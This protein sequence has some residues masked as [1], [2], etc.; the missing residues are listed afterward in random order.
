MEYFID[1]LLD[2]GTI[3]EE[4][5]KTFRPSV[6]NRLD[7]NTSGL[8]VAGKTLPGLQIM[9]AVFKDRSIH[10]YYQCVVKR[11]DQGETADHWIYHQG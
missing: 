5:L 9:A 1:Y 2:K 8:V 10:K 11:C 3:K 6:C 7:R 4:D